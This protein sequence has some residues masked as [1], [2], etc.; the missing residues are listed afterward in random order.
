MPIIETDTAGAA[1]KLSE[2]KNMQ[3]AVI[4]SELAAKFM[5]LEVIEK[6]FEDISGNT[7]RFLIMSLIIKTLA[8]DKKKIYNNMHL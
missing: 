2:E 8:I 7:T 6:N 5:D 1:K 3:S 4:A